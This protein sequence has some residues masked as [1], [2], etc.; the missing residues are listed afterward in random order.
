[1]LFGH[2]MRNILLLVALVGCVDG[3]DDDVGEDG[4]LAPI[5]APGKEDG[6][7]H[8]GLS[9]TADTSRTDVWKVTA[10]WED[11]DPKAGIA[12]PPNSGL[13]W[14]EKYAAWIQSFEWVQGVDGYSTT[15]KLT[16]PWGKTMPAPS[17]ECAETSLF[18]RVTFASWFGLP[19]QLEALD[20]H[21]KRIYFGHFGIRTAA[22]NA[23]GMPEFAVKYKDYTGKD[24]SV[25][26]TDATLQQRMIHGGTDD[27]EELAPGAVFG[28]YLDQLHLNKRVGY[29]TT[30]VLDYL[31]SDNLADSANTYN[32]VPDAVRSGDFLIERWQKI[33]IGHTLVV[34]EVV[35]ATPTTL[36]VALIS[37]SMPRRQGSQAKGAS[38]KSY[39]TGDYTGGPG[40]NSDGDPYVKLGG[41]LKR[42]RV[43]K[44]QNGYWTNTWM[45]GDEAHWINSTD[46]ERLSARPARF[47]D[48][49]GEVP[50]DQ[51]KTELLAQINDARHHL[52]Q[53]PASCSARDLREN[54]FRQ[55]Y[56]IEW[57][58]E[59][60][61]RSE[62]DA[63]LRILDDYVFAPL[64]Y[65]HSMTCCW[66]SSTSAM[67]EVIMAAA[68]A[69]EKAAADAMTCAAPT[70]FAAQNG[71]YQHWKDAA[72]AQGKAA[73]WR[74]Y[75]DDE[76]CHQSADVTASFAA[77]SFCELPTPP[78]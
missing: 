62:V 13:T 35:Q 16:T 43:A 60:K 53:Y 12:W 63:E 8:A 71:S 10:Q 47:G 21:G 3:G 4:Q 38:A 67:Y 54:A 15:V 72:A 24:F 55:L 20:D 31:G 11:K 77:E 27:Q 65:A 23:E 78:N 59:Q 39:F 7:Y 36:D 51:Q 40:M 28:A 30:L 69:D 19:L 68:R 26:P 25:W 58:L 42:F 45:A 2:D 61:G 44:K 66:D 48:L 57:R 74:D 6:Q 49:L 14:D 32:L 1:M 5:P 64:D 46:Y 76:A 17:L 73:A 37:G 41:G 22:G 9:L 18:L 50:L 34:K 52:A 56:D 29:F 70:V 75:A 33:G